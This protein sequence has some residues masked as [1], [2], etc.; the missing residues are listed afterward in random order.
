[1]K[2]S[3]AKKTVAIGG[4]GF[5]KSRCTSLAI[6]SREFT[7]WPSSMIYNKLFYQVNGSRLAL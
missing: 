6:V 5:K 3:T 2:P 7:S 4:G 1:M